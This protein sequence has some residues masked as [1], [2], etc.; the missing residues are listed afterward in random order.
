M[1]TQKSL[2][3]SGFSLN[4]LKKAAAS[5]RDALQIAPKNDLERDGVIQRFEYTFEL[6]WKTLKRYFQTTSQ[7]EE[8]NLKNLFREAGKQNLVK[9]VETWFGY[10][11][12]RNE[13]SHVYDRQVAERVFLS[14]KQF[15][16]DVEE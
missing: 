4:P 3:A 12:V 9:S 2:D 1:T 11:K 16:P 5:L 15:L 10:L 7:V 14:A 6:A 13:T 8:F